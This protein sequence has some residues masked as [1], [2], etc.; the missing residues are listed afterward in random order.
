MSDLSYLDELMARVQ[1]VPSQKT[2]NY[3]AVY[4]PT[5]I[6]KTTLLCQFPKSLLLECVDKSSGALKSAGF[7]PAN[8]P[9]LTATDLDDALRIL[10][11][12]AGEP[13]KH[14]Y[15]NIVVDGGSGLKKWTDQLAMSNECDGEKGKF[16]SYGYGDRSAAFYWAEILEKFDSLRTAGINVWLVC[17]DGVM[18]KKNPRGS[19]YPKNC[20]DVGG[21][22]RVAQTIKDADA[23]LYMDFITETVDVNKQSKVGKAVGGVHRV[24]YTMPH[25]SY[26]AKNRLGLPAEIILGSS[27]EEA[28]RA[29]RDALKAGKKQAQ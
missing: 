9:V 8:Y 1:T 16:A 25:A 29:F 13:E 22:D 20:P 23:V 21:K 12:L 24:M 3:C 10:E 5:G 27:Q 17:H 18:N 2:G 14:G 26:E 19:D 28:F 6:G 7:L 15:K 11:G 4:G